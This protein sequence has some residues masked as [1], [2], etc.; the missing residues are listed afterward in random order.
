M[1]VLLIQLKK[2]MDANFALKSL[3][4]KTGL[5]I[6]NEFTL[7]KN[8]FHANIAAK[9]FRKVVMLKFMKGMVTS[10]VVFSGA[11][12]GISTHGCHHS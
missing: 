10:V 8:L 1:K 2:Y 7:V 3:F 9:H 4:L 5:K 6:M 11:W 12:L